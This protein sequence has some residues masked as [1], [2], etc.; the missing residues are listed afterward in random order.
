[1]PDN[2]ELIRRIQTSNL[3]IQHSVMANG[4]IYACFVLSQK[5]RESVHVR[6]LMDLTA[7]AKT[8]RSDIHMQAIQMQQLQIQ[9]AT[10]MPC[11]IMAR[12][13]FLEINIAEK[14]QDLDDIMR[15]LSRLNNNNRDHDGNDNAI[16]TGT[17]WGL[18]SL[19]SSQLGQSSSFGNVIQSP[20]TTSFAGSSLTLLPTA[21]GHTPKW[22]SPYWEAVASKSLQNEDEPQMVH[23]TKGIERDNPLPLNSTIIFQ[24]NSSS[25][26]GV[27][28]AS[29]D[30][31]IQDEDED[32]FNMG[33]PDLIPSSLNS[34]PFYGFG[35]IDDDTTALL[36][37]KQQEYNNLWLGVPSKRTG[38]GNSA[39]SPHWDGHS[40]TLPSSK[41]WAMYSC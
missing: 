11:H 13:R 39:N 10:S 33:I 6:K 15:V 25:D 34:S 36:D 19:D 37:V 31:P 26:A 3:H 9:Y 38:G 24:Q 4:Y 28:D 23:N 12:M 29:I 30:S 22:T 27:N 40:A 20:I 16:H 41:D 32:E 2:E 17:L 1:M 5:P 8:L 7:G 18:P 35:I 21:D 14:R